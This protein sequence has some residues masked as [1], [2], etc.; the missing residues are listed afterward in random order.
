[1][2]KIAPLDLIEAKASGGTINV[3]QYR[4]S[5][6]LGHVSKPFWREQ[7]KNPFA[8]RDYKRL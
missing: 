3:W 5:Y 1:M 2:E 8:P 6:P 7:R 4:R